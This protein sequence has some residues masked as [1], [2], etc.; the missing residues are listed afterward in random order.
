LKLSKPKGVT[1]PYS[2]EF[3]FHENLIRILLSAKV[4]NERKDAIVDEF[5][6][7]NGFSLFLD[8]FDV[9]SY[10]DLS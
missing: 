8:I 4:L 1:F 10:F 2:T 6:R 7:V 9:G 3:E 5:F